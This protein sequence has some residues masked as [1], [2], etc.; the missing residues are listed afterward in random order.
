VGCSFFLVGRSVWRD[1]RGRKPA[2][3]SEDRGSAEDAKR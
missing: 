2:E 1:L 3:G